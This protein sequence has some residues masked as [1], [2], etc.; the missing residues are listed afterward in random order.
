MVDVELKKKLAAILNRYELKYDKLK[1][2]V[3]ILNKALNKLVIIP[4]FQAYQ[5]EHFTQLKQQLDQEF[6]A[7]A[8]EK[9]VSRLASVIAKIEKQKADKA[10]ELTHLIKKSTDS[11]SRLALKSEDK[12]AVTKLQKMLANSLE[13]VALMAQLEESIT[14]CTIS[15]LRELDEL[16]TQ[17]PVYNSPLQISA[18]IN[19]SLERL[20][21]YL[22]IPQALEAKREEIRGKLAGELTGENLLLAIELLNELVVDSFK[23]EQNRFKEFL[24]QLTNQLHNFDLFLKT[25]AFIRAEASEDSLQLEHAIKQDIEQ[26]KSHIYGSKSIEELS[27]KVNERLQDIG[28]LIKEYRSNEQKRE[29][30]YQ[31]QLAQLSIKLSESEHNV[32]IIKNMFNTQKYRI[33]HDSLTGLPNRESC[34]EYIIEALER[35]K[36]TKAPLSVAV[37]DIDHFKAINDTFGHLAGDKVLKKVAT[38]FKSL[39]RKTGFIACFAGEKFVFIF[40][41]TNRQMAESKLEELRM[42][43]DSCQFVYKNKKVEVTVSFGLT[44]VN[45]DDNIDSLFNRADNALYK[46]KDSGRNRIFSQ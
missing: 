31:T 43:V 14:L 46:A 5:D 3:D 34:D 8:V 2:Q 28:S 41:N 15:I 32:E 21:E 33:S 11:I 26:I 29:Q 9:K 40:E 22:S 36:A 27:L 10:K 1:L 18:K 44:E 38:I 39:I 17:M 4:G 42:A 13:N 20:L 45:A 7:A 16:R 6:D 25:S 23:I 12:R 37:A 35:W 24:Q 30:D 19:Q